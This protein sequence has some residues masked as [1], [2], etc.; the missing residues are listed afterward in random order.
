V[1]TAAQA[2]AERDR[3]TDIRSVWHSFWRPPH[4]PAPHA[5]Q[6]AAVLSRIASGGCR[7]GGAAVPGAA[8]PKS[9]CQRHCRTLLEWLRM[10]LEAGG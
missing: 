9:R 7:R 5:V 10:A 2:S 1:I 8:R 3:P 4:R 6:L